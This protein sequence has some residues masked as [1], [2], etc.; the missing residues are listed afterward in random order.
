MSPS[1][2]ENYN[3]YIKQISKS[4]LANNK[5]TLLLDFEDGIKISEKTSMSRS[6]DVSVEITETLY[7]PGGLFSFSYIEYFIETQPFGWSV[8]RREPD[9]KR[10]RDYI[11]KKFPQYVI[12]P[13]IQTKSVFKQ[14]DIE[15]NKIYF[16]EFLSSLIKNPEL[17]ACKYLEEFLSIDDYEGFRGVRK[18][19]DTEPAP[20][21]LRQYSNLAGRAKLTIQCQNPRLLDSY[22]TVFIDRYEDILRKMKES[23]VNMTVKSQELSVCIEKVG[24]HFEELSELFSDVGFDS[25]AGL[26]TD[27]SFLATAYKES[28]VQQAESIRKYLEVDV[29]FHLLEANSFREFH[30]HREDV[31]WEFYK[32]GKDLQSK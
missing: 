20:T 29:N 18:M 24:S 5:K 15:V 19:R 31:Y 22:N 9:F 4:D 2:K 3:E 10:L 1:D 28:V 13:L 11:I 6:D 8:S 14:S 23:L 21:S 30:K 27:I 16:Q 25:N 26:Y 7:H 17:C 12:P 32:V